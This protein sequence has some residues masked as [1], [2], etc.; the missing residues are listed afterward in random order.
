MSKPKLQK[1]LGKLHKELT[2]KGASEDYRR[3]TGN[4][5][6]HTVSINKDKITD[7]LKDAITQAVNVSGQG[8]SVLKE[9]SDYDSLLNTFMEEVRSNFRDLRT[10]HPES[11][12]FV[13]GARS[14]STIKVILLEGEGRNNFNLAQTQYKNALQKFYDGVLDRI[15]VVLERKSSSTKNAS[16]LVQQKGQGSVFNLEH[17][18]SSSNVKA[19]INDTI[20]AT[21]TAEYSDAELDTLEKDLKK[22]GLKTILSVKK[23]TKTGKASV[24]LGSQRLNVAQSASEQKMK[25]RLV[26][27]LEKA[28]KKL[29]SDV[30]TTE[31]SDS[32][33][34]AM[35]KTLFAQMMDSFRKEVKGGRITGTS[36]KIIGAITLAELDVS[37]TLKSGSNFSGK[38]LKKKAVKKSTQ[39]QTAAR[40]P[41]QLIAMLNKKLPA[42]IRRN[43][44][45]PALENRTGRFA[46]SVEITGVQQTPK[47]FPSF[48]YTYQ[49][50]PY[51]V[52][53]VGRGSEP[54]ATPERDPRKLIDRSIREIAREFAAGRFFTRRV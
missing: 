52:F 7:I 36:E 49:K 29:D 10:L 4:L 9:I 27:A 35:E 38:N 6:T 43:M 30:V 31:G 41:L 44:N 26:V 23:N 3:Q 22:L 34:D 20:Y 42:V 13:S 32:F 33:L 53:E 18:K 1:F 40:T 37:P 2:G 15:G 17:A 16:G 50:N 5:L 25:K 47:G 11:I 51:Q 46:D 28:L 54:W 39:R 21:L 19:F 12:I 45:A 48:A 8:A 14:A 24:F